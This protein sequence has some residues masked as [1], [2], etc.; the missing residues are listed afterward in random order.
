M[1][2][3]RDAEEVR[4]EAAGLLRKL[5]ATLGRPT[6]AMGE[7]VAVS[8]RIVP[9]G[10][11]KENECRIEV[12]CH[13]FGHFDS[14]WDHCDIV[15]N[16][17]AGNEYTLKPDRRG[18]AADTRVLPD[19]VL[20]K[21]VNIVR[22]DGPFLVR[23]RLS[24]AARVT[25]VGELFSEFQR[26]CWSEDGSVR[27]A[28]NSEIGGRLA[29]TFTAEGPTPTGHRVRFRFFTNADTEVGAEMRLWPDAGKPGQ[30]VAGWYGNQTD[31][32]PIENSRET[33]RVKKV[34]LFFEFLPPA[35][36]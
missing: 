35:E 7:R 20:M 33:D 10:T 8:I 4:G 31:L 1:T 18:Y 29:V 26:D 30:L 19:G 36:E 25:N 34:D 21:G 13:T 5:S 24:V 27:A 6:H 2:D 17:G 14:G 32:A 12:V 23:E 28:I 9:S 3:L 16:D 11:E 22:R 15:L